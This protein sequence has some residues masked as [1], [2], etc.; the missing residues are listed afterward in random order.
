MPLRAVVGIGANVGDRLGAM[1]AAVLAMRRIM[2]VE[3]LSRVYETAPV[4]GPPQP[5]YLNAAALVAYDGSAEDLLD[6][7]QGIEAQL[8][9]ARAE[10]WGPR[11]IDLDILWIEGLALETERLVVPH[12]RLVERGFALRPLADVA[13]NARD[14]ETGRPYAALAAASADRVRATDLEIYG[15][16]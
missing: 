13:P 4:G 8:G 5:D 1:R 3:R 15:A 7:I 11:T 9:R 16:S 12:P 6:A 14:P 10:R 2:K